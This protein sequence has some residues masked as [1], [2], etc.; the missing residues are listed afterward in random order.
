M[1]KEGIHGQKTVK[2]LLNYIMTVNGLKT[3]EMD[4][5]LL[6]I[7]MEVNTKET[8]KTIL[9]QVKENL[10]IVMGVLIQVIGQMT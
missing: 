7:L 5:V 10:F 8:F 4:R 1:E 2:H 3:E 6:L 9:N